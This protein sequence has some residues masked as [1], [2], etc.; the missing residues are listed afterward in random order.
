MASRANPGAGQMGMMQQQDPMAIM[1]QMSEGGQVGM[2]GST[3]KWEQYNQG[4]GYDSGIQ[5][6]VNASGPD[7]DSMQYMAAQ[8]APVNV[9][10]MQQ[11]I[12][13]MGKFYEVY[14][15]TL[16]SFRRNEI[17][18]PCGVREAFVTTFSK[19]HE[20][21]RPVAIAA[22]PL[23]GWRIINIKRE[24]GK[25]ELNANQYLQA[26]EIAIRSI[27]FFEM[28]QWLM[29]TQ[30]GQLHARALPKDLAS[31]MPNLEK[32]NDVVNTACAAF[33]VN[34][35]YAGLTFEVKA[36]VRTDIQNLRY[37]AG[38]DYLYGNNGMTGAPADNSSMKDVYDMIHRGA[39]EYRGEATGFQAARVNSMFEEERWNKIRNDINNLTPEN[40]AEFQLGRFFNSIGKP[41]HYVIPE[42]DWKQIKHAF[43]KHPEMGQEQTVQP[44]CFR[45]VIIDLEADSGWFSTLVRS[46]DLDMATV[47]TDPTKLLPLLE[48]PTGGGVMSVVA[49][50]MEELVKTDKP[51]EIELDTFNAL[52]AALPVIAVKD[53]VVANNS[54]QLESTLTAVNQRL[55]GKITTPNAVSFN[56]TIWDTFDCESPEDKIR[57]FH[58]LPF[59]F[60]DSKIQNQPSLFEACKKMLG[61]FKAGIISRELC[62]FIDERLTAIFN[63]Y[64]INAG[65]YDP[66]PHQ[67]H[68][69][70]VE[71]LIR[72][73]DELDLH[74]DKT[75][76]MMF[77]LFNQV[78]KPHYLTESLKLFTFGHPFKAGDQELGAIEQIKREQ[79]LVL[80][81]NLSVTFVN[82]KGGPIYTDT[83]LPVVMKRSTFPEYFDVIEKGFASTMGE[84]SV[85]VTDKLICFTQSSENLWLF[86]YSAIDKNMA[87]LRHVSRRN[88][89]V[90]L[91][92]D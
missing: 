25:D 86:S 89:L 7:Q 66:F 68:H 72:D 64:L 73:H 56:S 87:T 83:N 74:L 76:E 60:K 57:L 48:N 27:L 47:L 63:D 52:D 22:A 9:L 3:I 45:I 26:A 62:D 13:R 44:G 49:Y 51:T 36:P 20:F 69:L 28:V 1:R 15:Q 92:L 59:L 78:D 65:G 81:R 55:A 17:G 14:R 58:D 32:M 43:R 11:I 42:S 39:R 82:Q 4:A 21:N 2:H 38:A 75:D 84:Q 88:P 10:F 41:K 37:E 90:F 12:A 8:V 24:T 53:V 91:S 29:K 40:K 35:P 34:N 80:E 23:F 6:I 5:E 19:H 50:P 33:G 71:S 31:K 70:S 30:E 77:R 85:E 67:P 16:E 54:K 46:E 79:E 61:Y 18:N